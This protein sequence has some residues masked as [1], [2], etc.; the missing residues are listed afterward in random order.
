MLT[1]PL[2]A[3]VAADDDWYSSWRARELS[4]LDRAGLTYLD[5]TG[6]ALY[7]E[8]LIPA[9]GERLAPSVLGNPH[10]AHA[11]S[12]ASTADAHAARGA[13]LDFLDADPDQY[14]CILTTNASAACRLVGESF[15]F[16]PTSRLLLAADN[17][18]SVVGIREYARARGAATSLMPVD[19]DLRLTGTVDA[20]GDRPHGPSL[21]AFPAQS[22]FSGVRH[23]LSLVSTAREAGWYV[24]LDAAAFVPTMTL[25]LRRTPADFVVLSLYKIIGHPAGVGALVAR[26]DALVRLRRPSFAGGTVSWVSVQGDR[27]RLLGGEAAFEDGTLPFSALGIVPAA[28][29]AARRADRARLARHLGTLT[30]RLV[31]ELRGLRHTSGTPLVNI[32]GPLDHANRG[33]T[34]AV[35]LRDAGGRI[36]PYWDVEAG[37][38]RERVAVRGGCFCNPGCAE[39]AFRF[40]REATARC[41]D[42]LGA[43]FSIPAFARC[44]GDTPVG[45]IRFS[46]G[47][48]SVQADIDHAIGFLRRHLA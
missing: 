42:R 1:S 11:P 35:T 28:L 2:A 12:E 46:M 34:V 38:R 33:A 23:P 3:S 7:P 43:S 22:N 15:P 9:P 10:S 32:H 19:D 45:A 20:V 16:E 5:Y 41:L 27:H 39:A 17:H 29:S 24:L 26:R 25:S 18:N 31:D 4:R 36:I 48:G 30:R 47:L 21:F 6:A 14:A 13:I 40:P 37:A 44:L 8:S